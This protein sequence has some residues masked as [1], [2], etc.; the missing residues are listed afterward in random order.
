MNTDELQLYAKYAGWSGM[1]ELDKI[2]VMERR[3][4]LVRSLGIVVGAVTVPFLGFGH[5]MFMFGLI[6]FAALWSAFFQFYVFP[7]KKHWLLKSAWLTLGDNLM[8]SG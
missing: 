7:Y 4:V 2:L 8:A 3:I 5:V 6:L 1:T